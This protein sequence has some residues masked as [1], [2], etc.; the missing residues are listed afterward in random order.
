MRSSPTQAAWTYRHI[1]CG[2]TCP[3]TKPH[4]G[5]EAAHRLVSISP[6]ALAASCK[7][8]SAMIC[9][10]PVVSRWSHR[11]APQEN[12]S[13]L[14]ACPSASPP[15]ASVFSPLLY[16]A[17]E[18][19]NC[20]NASNFFWDF[21]RKSRNGWDRIDLRQLYLKAVN[22][23]IAFRDGKKITGIRLSPDTRYFVPNPAWQMP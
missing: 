8:A 19:L 6:Q 9:R 17:W 20:S 16:M 2:H 23:S 5:S 18:R 10:C 22:K 3:S 7:T 15:I 1:R 12:L 13:G 4:T 14:F 11:A 21:L